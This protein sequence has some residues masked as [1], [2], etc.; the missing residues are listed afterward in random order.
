MII[1]KEDIIAYDLDGEI[2]CEGCLNEE[3]IRNIKQ[4][5]IITEKDVDIDRYIFCDRCDELLN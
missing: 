3:E 4:N 2:V 5:Q 1:E